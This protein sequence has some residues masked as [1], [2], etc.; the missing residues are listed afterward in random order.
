MSYEYFHV[1]FLIKCPI[2]ENH[3]KGRNAVLNEDTKQKVEQLK[4]GFF[5]IDRQVIKK[6]LYSRGHPALTLLHNVLQYINKLNYVFS[7]I[8]IKKM[9]INSP[10][11]VFLVVISTG[12]G[13]AVC[14]SRCSCSSYGGNIVQCN[15]RSFQHVPDLPGDTFSL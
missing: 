1:D 4:L 7:A 13:N 12:L 11:F 10:F 14:P 2:T 5:F 15:S 8:Q 6:K 3:S 9:T